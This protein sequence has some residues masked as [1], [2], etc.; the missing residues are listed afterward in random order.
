MRGTLRRLRNCRGIFVDRAVEQGLVFG[1]FN[2][3]ARHLGLDLVRIL[4]KPWGGAKD[5]YHRL[6]AQ[7]RYS[8]N[9]PIE[10]PRFP[11]RVGPCPQDIS[12]IKTVRAGRRRPQETRGKVPKL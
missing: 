3:E 6:L 9:A 11:D 8:H 4:P 10:M 12:A 2:D 7:H 5:E 1:A